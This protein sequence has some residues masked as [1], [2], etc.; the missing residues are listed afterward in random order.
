[1][2]NSLHWL[3]PFE[4][5]DS[6][7]IMIELSK[8]SDKP[9]YITDHHNQLLELKG[10]IDKIQTVQTWDTAKKITNPF[11]YIFLSLQKRTHR[12]IAACIPLSRSYF[13]MVELW[14][15]LGPSLPEGE[16]LTAH[17]AEGPGGFLEAVMHRTHPKKCR[18]IAMTLR[19]TEKTIPGWRKSQQFL[20]SNPSVIVT[21]GADGTGNLYSLEN[22]ESFR[23]TAVKHL[24]GLAHLYTAD[25]GFDFS[26]DFNAQ[27]NTV[28][29]LLAAEGLC[30]L[31]ILRPGGIMIIKLFDTTYAGTLDLLWL[32]SGCFER[33]AMTKPLTSRPAN[34]ERY[35]IGYKL[36]SN[37]PTW[38]FDTLKRLTALD[39]PSGWSQIFKTRPYTTEWLNELKSFQTVVE[40][41][42]INNIQLTLNLIKQPTKT[43]IHNLLLLN[44]R[45]SRNWCT[46]HTI[47]MN[48]QY[49]DMTDEQIVSS[50]LE[51]A[52]EPFLTSVVHTSSPGQFRPLPM[53]RVSSSPHVLPPPTGLAWRSALPASILGREPSQKVSETPPSDPSASPQSPP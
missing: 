15:L 41:Q 3:S 51:E 32:L 25:G 44:V 22:Q 31:N 43:L 36:R 7:E 27:E 23:Q 28:Q 49:K 24:D 26:A 45:S 35:W 2:D 53:H 4:H 37:I 52:L 38:V 48:K 5:I 19:S 39:A 21:Y 10:E 50:N 42:Q 30:G 16:Y 11:E 13:K 47:S 12:S 9:I 20:T 29:R 34:S 40:S 1:M 18:M 46:T 33:T 17:S 8:E 6:P 14:D